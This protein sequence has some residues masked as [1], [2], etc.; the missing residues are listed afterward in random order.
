MKLKKLFTLALSIL[1]VP[2]LSAQ[3]KEVPTNK[4]IKTLEKNKKT[5][6]VFISDVDLSNIEI[7]DN[8][9]VVIPRILKS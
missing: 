1:F 9:I 5:E 8:S 2:A 4:L 3:T 6:I 7:L